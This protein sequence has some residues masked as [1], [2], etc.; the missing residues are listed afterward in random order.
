MAFDVF[1]FDNRVVHQHPHHQRQRQQCDGVEG[2]AKIL[3]TQKGRNH[4]Q[5][6]RRRRH[7]GRAPVTQK[8]PHH[9]HRQ[10]STL[11]QQLHR[12]AKVLSHGGGVVD[13]LRQPDL[14]KT[15]LQFGHGR[16]HATGHGHLAGAFGAKHLKAHHLPAV[17]RGQRA[18]LGH[19][20]QYAGHIT[21]PD[22]AAVGQAD[23]E[24]GQLSGG[25]DRA[26]GAH[27][28]LG[29]ADV[30]APAR[31]LLLH[32]PQPAR[33]V[34][35]RHLQR[36]HARGIE[37]NPHL[38]GDTA[39]AFDSAHARYCQQPL[40]HGVVDEP[41]QILRV[42]QAASAG[43]SGCRRC[44]KSQDHATG[45]RGFGDRGVAQ[46]GRQVGPHPGHRV[47]HVVDGVRDRFLQDEFDGDRHL[48]IEHLGVDVFHTLQRR[49]R[50][51][52]LAR[53]FGLQLRRC[54]AGERGTDGDDRQ[55]NVREIL[56]HA[57]AVGQQAG[58][59][60]QHE[61][62][63]SRHRVLDRERGEVHDC[64]LFRSGHI[65]VCKG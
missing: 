64:S 22:L 52:Q 27:R 21:E 5:R 16:A 65:R 2:V 20:V 7:Q 58:Q 28:L 17:Q 35:G 59:R 32:Q 61:Q 19:R 36:R 37:L 14:R 63:N 38:A 31:R 41:A 26:D 40:G 9:Q 10:Q 44:S 50:V 13:R 23:L 11:V 15:R 51:F 33:H 56:H 55:F 8:P 12:A 6:Q 39:H 47:A 53:D 42:E 45:G 60:Q 24:L 57:G 54:R 18:R 34:D 46:L 25:L 49:H 1:D 3:Q 43:R 4:R 62:Q 29:A 30:A 48:A